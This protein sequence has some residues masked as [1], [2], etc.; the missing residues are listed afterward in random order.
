[1]SKKQYIETINVR[2]LV[3][4]DVSGGWGDPQRTTRQKPGNPKTHLEE[5]TRSTNLQKMRGRPQQLMTTSQKCIINNKVNHDTST[6]KQ[7]NNQQ[8]DSRKWHK[9]PRDTTT[10]LPWA[11]FHFNHTWAVVWAHRWRKN[12]FAPPPV[13]H[14]SFF[15]W[16]LCQLLHKQG[17]CHGQTSRG[18]WTL[19]FVK[20]DFKVD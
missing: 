13:W 17:L 4:R 18:N 2:T 11:F 14:T 8:W 1:M 15:L 19:H 16:T 10:V 3:G 20:I 6:E 7:N 12:E 9:N 5:C